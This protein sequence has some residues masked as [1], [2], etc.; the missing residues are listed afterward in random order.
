MLEW[1]AILLR[2]AGMTY[3]EWAWVWTGF[4]CMI[5]VDVLVKACEAGGVRHSDYMDAVRDMRESRFGWQTYAWG[6][7]RF[8]KI[9][10]LL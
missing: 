8:A 1:G 10:A 9:L 2:G 6:S 3:N 5:G 4:W 7:T